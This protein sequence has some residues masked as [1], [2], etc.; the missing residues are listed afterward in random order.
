MI[1]ASLLV[2]N[3]FL[4]VCSIA[5]AMMFYYNLNVCLNVLM[6]GILSVVVILLAS[7]ANLATVA[8]TISI[9]KDWIVVLADGNKDTLAGRDNITTYCCNNKDMHFGLISHSLVPYSRIL[10]YLGREGNTLSLIMKLE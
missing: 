5:L 10:N 8:N 2:Q 4:A 7:G 9:E 6:F 3:G 1:I